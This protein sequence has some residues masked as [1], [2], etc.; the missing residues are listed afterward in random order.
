MGI[1]KGSRVLET[2]MDCEDPDSPI[3][4]NKVLAPEHIQL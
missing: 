4:P 3:N 2:T 1:L